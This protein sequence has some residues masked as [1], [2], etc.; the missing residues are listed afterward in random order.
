MITVNP[1]VIFKTLVVSFSDISAWEVVTICCVFCLWHV[2]GAHTLYHS[3]GSYCGPCE[4]SKLFSIHIY[5][6]RIC[7]CLLI[8]Y[9]KE[10]QG[11]L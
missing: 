10:L 4:F 5:G 8:I 7:T 2:Y 1:A 11:V 3:Q 6:K 9:F